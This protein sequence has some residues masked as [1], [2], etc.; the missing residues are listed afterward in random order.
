MASAQCEGDVLANQSAERKLQ[1]LLARFPDSEVAHISRRLNISGL[2]LSKR[3]GIWKITKRK[4]KY[5]RFLET[6]RRLRILTPV[7]CQIYPQ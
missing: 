3:S 2:R 7:Y 4:E 1:R 6:L 5:Y